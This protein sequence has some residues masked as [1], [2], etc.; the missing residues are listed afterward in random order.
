MAELRTYPVWDA[1][2][3]WFHWINAL[4]IVALVALGLVILNSKALGVGN[5]GK[6]LLKTI[7]VW[8]GYLFALNLLWRIAWAFLGNRHARW[9]ALLPGGAGYWASLRSYVAAFVAGHPEQYIG[10]NPLARIGVAGLL[11]LIA[12]Q[13]SCNALVGAVQV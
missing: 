6:A 10:H 11:L 13:V 12:V 4:C 1:P 2:T 3:R 7:H 8:I 9:R 5:D